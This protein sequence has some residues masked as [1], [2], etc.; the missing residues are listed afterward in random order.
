MHFSVIVAAIVYAPPPSEYLLLA[1][2]ALTATGVLTVFVGIEAVRLSRESGAPRG[3]AI[4]VQ[5]TVLGVAL[6][7]ATALVFLGLPYIAVLRAV[8]FLPAVVAAVILVLVR[9]GR[10]P[11]P[12]TRPR[13]LTEL[14]HTLI[15]QLATATV[16]LLIAFVWWADFL[17]KPGTIVDDDVPAIVAAV[18]LVFVTVSVIASSFVHLSRRHV[19]SPKSRQVLKVGQIIWMVL[20]SLYALP[21]FYDVHHRM[22]P[23]EVETTVDDLPMYRDW[24]IGIGGVFNELGLWMLVFSAVTALLVLIQLS[25]LPNTAEVH[26]NATM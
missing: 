4:T 25:R 3:S 1:V 20:G 12:A 9:L 16:A 19:M 6:A 26:T 22:M 14:K 8:I 2:G 21:W 13:I 15:I 11:Q 18:L 23:F 10:P 5:K 24:G 17:S 7:V